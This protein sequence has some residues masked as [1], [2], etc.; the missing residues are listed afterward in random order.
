MFK[1]IKEFFLFIRLFRE[2]QMIELT[3]AE[4]VKLE[5]FDKDILRSIRVKAYD[6]LV[7]EVL[8]NDISREYF[9]G[10]KHW[11]EHLISYFRKYK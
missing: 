2:Y 10:Y 1:I 5:A 8:K 4:K 6:N 7:K 9:L 3:D 11:T